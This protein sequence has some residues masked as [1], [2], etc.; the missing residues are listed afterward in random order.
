VL[1]LELRESAALDQLAQTIEIISACQRLGVRVALDDFGTVHSSLHYFRRLAAS[2]IKIDRSLIGSMLDETEDLAIIEAIIGLT[3]TFQRQ[4]IAKGV[5][6][7]EQGALLLQLGCDQAQGF[8]I[9][10]AMPG[11][12]VPAWRMGWRPDPRWCALATRYWPRADFPLLALG[13]EHRRWARR[14]RQA[15]TH[16]E[17]VPTLTSILTRHSN[18]HG[19]CFTH[20]LERR[21][22]AHRQHP[23]LALLLDTHMRFHTIADRITQ[24]QRH[25]DHAG[26]RQ[27]LALL[28]NELTVLLA[29][30]ERVQFAVALPE[31]DR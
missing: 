19:D 5:E 3:E 8:I 16:E 23:E 12:Q 27:E 17:D 6:Q 11:S 13:I 25:G 15:L 4:V 2:D 20:W 26:A 14:I 29:A 30:V 10:P 18:E 28:D 1:V 21:G 7:V 31:P 9:A 22:R 24:R